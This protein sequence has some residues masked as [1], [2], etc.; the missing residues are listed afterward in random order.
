MHAL[1]EQIE[2]PREGRFSWDGLLRLIGLVSL[3][4][5]WL[6][7][8]HYLP[9]YA[10][11]SDAM[12]FVAVFAWMLSLAVN[13]DKAIEIPRLFLV[14]IAAIA[15]PW[16]QFGGGLL[17]FAGEAWLASLY[18]GGFAGSICI[19]FRWV[20]SPEAEDVLLQTVIAATLVAGLISTGLCF[21]Q[22]LL[23]EDWLGIFIA[24]IGATGRPFANLAQPN[25]LATLL[26]MSVVALAW[27]YESRRIGGWGLAC[28]AA[29][30]TIGLSFTQSRAGYLSVSAVCVWWW[31]KHSALG[32]PRLKRWWPAV[33]ILMLGLFATVL[34]KISIA[35][36]LAGNRPVPLFDNNGRWLMWK[37]IIAG[38]L[39]SP[40]IGYGW[41][42]TPAAQMAGAIRYPGQ[43]ATGYAHNFGLDAMAWLG[44]PLGVGVCALGVFWLVSRAWA[45]YGRLPILSFALALPVLVHSLFEFPFAYAFFLF[46]VGIMIGVIEAF[47]P[48]AAAT[49][50]S[51]RWI[52]ALSIGL[53][54]LGFQIAREY[55][56]A[57]EDFRFLR[58][59]SMRMGTTPQ[60]RLR[61][62]FLVLSQMEA[63]LDVGRTKPTT[64]MSIEQIE[65]IRFVTIK[66]SWAPPAFLYAAV[67]EAN[68]L[69]EQAA[70]QMRVI[71]GMYGKTY[72]SGAVSRLE[73]LR[74][75]W[76]DRA[77]APWPHSTA[78]EK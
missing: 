66:Y 61:P 7:P 23:L 41:D 42:H 26:V 57:E 48:E 34:P 20:R 5:S 18:L 77:S 74:G 33:W 51:K 44:V 72:Y 58:F 69:H 67:L 76:T 60:G 55:V 47:H 4:M 24:N 17:G 73:E 75:E 8:N 25:L 49:R 32:A 38:I 15:I 16:F 53:A 46:P 19:G 78:A 71:R 11:H 14:V 22:W 2:T 45:A 37:Q 64:G 56:P 35:F 30:L 59:E 36:E 9:W 63:L 62:E 68:G 52:L 70:H 31:L 40:W 6:M 12:A 65:R 50:M 29:F 39:E 1:A 3:G 28:G 43:L 54:T 13:S 10:F 21:F 27:T